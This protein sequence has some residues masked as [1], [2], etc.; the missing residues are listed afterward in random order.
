MENLS[1]REN[2]NA[3]RM[4]V[5]RDLFKVMIHIYSILQKQNCVLFSVFKKVTQSRNFE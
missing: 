2:S 1:F 5:Y 3:D 4:Y